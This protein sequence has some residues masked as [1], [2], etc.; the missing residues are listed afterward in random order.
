M[1]VPGALDLFIDSDSGRIIIKLHLTDKHENHIFKLFRSNGSLGKGV[2]KHLV[3]QVSN[4]RIE[5]FIDSIMDTVVDLAKY[6]IKFGFKEDSGEGENQ[7]SSDEFEF[8]RFQADEE[9]SHNGVL[10]GNIDTFKGI[11]DV[12]DAQTEEN[13]KSL[14][15][16]ELEAL[17]KQMVKVKLNAS[18]RMNII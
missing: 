6:Q 7:E 9:Q 15:A 4:N 16:P 1:S 13:T 3:V 5:V 2:W 8:F 10:V 18:Y 17:Y 14:F 12:G 11:D